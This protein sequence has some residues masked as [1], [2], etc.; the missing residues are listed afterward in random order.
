M[1]GRGIP[2]GRGAILQEYCEKYPRLAERFRGLVQAT[3]IVR[4]AE[5]QDPVRLGPY[6]ITRTLAIGGMGKVYEAEDEELHR[7]V[8]VKTIRLGRAADPKLL[9]R[10]EYEREA[11]ARLHHTHIVPIYSSGEDDGLLYF[12]MPL[13]RGPSL[14]DLVATI[15]RWPSGSGDAAQATSWEEILGRATTDATWRRS[16]RRLNVLSDG[17]SSPTPSSRSVPESTDTAAVQPPLTE[18]YFR[19]VAEILAVVAEALHTP[20]KRAS[21]TSTSSP[22]TS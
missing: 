21:S 6:R 20:T 9:E 3:S 15:S 11:L 2:R 4:D 17:V 22:R 16:V 13:I 7:T 8:A 14:A 12:A 18:E 10:F 1:G 5:D 19:H